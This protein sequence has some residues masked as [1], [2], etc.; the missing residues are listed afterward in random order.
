MIT[1]DLEAGDTSQVAA[2]LRAETERVVLRRRLA[3]LERTTRSFEDLAVVGRLTAG[4]LHEV[5]NAL[6]GA[7]RFVRLA[8]RTDIPE[9]ERRSS[10][11]SGLQAIERT[12]E[13]LGT[14]L[15]FSQGAVVKEEPRPLGEVVDEAVQL[16]ED[17]RGG[18]AL[19][20]EIAPRSIRIPGSLLQVLINLLRNAY[21]ACQGRGSVQ[22]KARAVAGELHII[23]EDDGL[24]FEPSLSEKI[25]E[26]FYRADP[27]G[28]GT[29]L[30]LTL[31][32]KLVERH[33]GRL[34]AHSN[35]QG[36]GARFTVILP[37]PESDHGR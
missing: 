27:H 34:K 14:T 37:H 32:R 20:L 24:G 5:R 13:I 29:G 26:A 19:Q 2:Y 21:R 11:A 30:G 25:F 22:L 33:Q 10:L 6:D 8:S 16:T 35:G 31:S 12:V 3:S 1:I 23:V 15:A 17:S 7:R 36:R 4:I 9:P 18:A 28:P